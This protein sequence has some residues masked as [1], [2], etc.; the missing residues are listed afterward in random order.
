MNRAKEH[1]WGQNTMPKAFTE[2]FY[3]LI[4]T[5]WKRHRFL[6]SDIQEDLYRYIG[7]KCKAYGYQAFAIN[8]MEEH[9]H[10]VLRLPPTVTVAEAVGKLKGSSSRFLTKNFDLPFK[11]QEGYGALTFGKRDLDKT[12]RILCF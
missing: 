4:W 2:L 5:T 6:K 10:V 8:G 3:H 9:I 7:H 1:C 11:W 12:E